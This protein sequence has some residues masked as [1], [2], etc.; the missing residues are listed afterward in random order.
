MHCLWCLPG[1][2]R[3]PK[4]LLAVALLGSSKRLPVRL[5]HGIL[6]VLRV[7]LLTPLL[8][9]GKNIGF[10]VGSLVDSGRG[11]T[12]ILLTIVAL[13]VSLPVIAL[14]AIIV[15]IIS[16]LLAIVILPL[17]RTRTLLRAVCGPGRAAGVR[18]AV[19]IG[20]LLPVGARTAQLAAR[21][22]TLRALA[23]SWGIGAAGLLMA[24]PRAALI[25]A[26]GMIFRRFGAVVSAV[27]PAW[28]LCAWITVVSA[29]GILASGILATRILPTGFW[30]AG[31]LTAGVIPRVL[32]AHMIAARVLST[33][34]WPAGVLPARAGNSRYGAARINAALTA[35]SIAAIG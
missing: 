34:I 27:W 4:V 33:R 15:V 6:H 1:V 3:L 31:I 11:V 2:V 12:P 10:F 29:S 16:G 21:L 9:V 25:L 19:E 13:P 24:G 17:R 30:L 20:V 22:R 5:G 18:I 26:A 28:I 7:A 32:T 8:F 35:A 14:V 23:G